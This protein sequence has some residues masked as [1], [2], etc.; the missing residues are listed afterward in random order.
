MMYIFIL[1]GIVTSIAALVLLIKPKFGFDFG[2]KYFLSSAF[3][4]GTALISLLLAAA[5]Y[6]SSSSSRFPA[7][8]EIFSLCV[9]TGGVIC[10]VLPTSAFREIVTWELKTFSPY[11]RIL[12]FVYGLIGGFFIYAGT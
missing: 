1:L 9:L 10:L 2:R 4:Y 7:F 8:F 5:L 11:G 12:G 6:F 3:Q